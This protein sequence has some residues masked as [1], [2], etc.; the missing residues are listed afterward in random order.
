MNES[1]FEEVE[2]FIRKSKEKIHCIG[3]VGLDFSPRYLTNGDEDKRNQREVFRRYIEL[4]N[5]F[6]VPV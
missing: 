2:G 6:K 1:D 5:E 3:E 4:A